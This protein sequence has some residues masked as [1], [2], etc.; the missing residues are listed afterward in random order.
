M[1]GAGGVT[2]CITCIKAITEGVI[3]HTLN[4]KNV[5]EE[6]DLNLV[7]GEPLKTNIDYAMS[8]SLGFGGQNSSVIVGKYQK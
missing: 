2:E 7:M 1:M 5:D 6:I 8:N 4:L 3:P